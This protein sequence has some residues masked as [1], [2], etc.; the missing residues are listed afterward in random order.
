MVHSA[1]PAKGASRIFDVVTKSGLASGL[2]EY[3]RLPIGAESLERIDEKLE[4]MKQNIEALRAIASEQIYKISLR[5][6]R[7]N[8]NNLPVS[9]H[10]PRK[11]KDDFRVEVWRSFSARDK[12]RFSLT[13]PVFGYP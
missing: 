13:F 6:C 4:N 5:I 7:N 1:D 3:L 9:I 8:E 10:V 12:Y 2:E 11:E